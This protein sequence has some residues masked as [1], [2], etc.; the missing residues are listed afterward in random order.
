MERTQELVL[1][2]VK[3]MVKHPDQ[4]ELYLTDEKDEQGEITIINI[5]VA[6]E[7]VGLCIGKGGKTAEALRTIIGLI[8]FRQCEKRCYAKIDAPKFP[9][10]HFDY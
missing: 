5:K 9:K 8:G 4:V 2:L 10:N 3:G 6:K 1:E 7:D